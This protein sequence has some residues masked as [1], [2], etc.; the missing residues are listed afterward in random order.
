MLP[1]VAVIVPTFNRG[2]LLEEN[3]QY[4][5]KNLKYEGEVRVIIGDDSDQDELAFNP[6]TT[7]C[8]FPILYQRNKPSLGLGA[9]L[10]DLLRRCGC[11]YAL[12]G[13]DDHRLIKPLDLTQHVRKL[14]EDPAAAWIRL[15]GV[16]GHN[17]SASLNQSYWRVDWYSPELYI[18]SN[19]MHLKRWKEWPLYPEGLK[20]GHTE[21]S[22]CH[23][24]IDEA[25]A[26]LGSGLKPLDVLIPL[27]QQED[28]WTETGHSLQMQGY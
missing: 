3:L 14:V 25:R 23:T 8:R 17:F 27:Q 28:A 21:E 9:N 12:Q 15:M 7:E 11:D 5:S 16:A 4:L 20:L 22:Y 2:A 13:D 10:N 24:C 1:T 19:R 6:V 26:K 18:N